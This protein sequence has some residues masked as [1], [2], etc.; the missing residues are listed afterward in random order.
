MIEKTLPGVDSVYLVYDDRDRVVATQD[1]EMR[2][3]NEWLFTKYDAMNRPVISGIMT[4]STSLTRSFIQSEIEDFYTSSSKRYEERTSTGNGYTDQTYP[5]TDSYIS[6]KTTHTIN[7]YDNYDHLSLTGFSGLSFDNTNNIDSYANDDG[8]SNGYFDR[9]INQLTGT[10]TILLDGSGSNWI[11]SSNYYDN[12]Y[13]IIQVKST[14]YPQGSTMLSTEFDFV[15]KVVENLEIQT[16]NSVENKIR[17]THSYDHAGRLK[18]KYMYYNNEIGILMAQNEYNELDE[19]VEKNLHSTDYSSFIQS[20]DYTYN[21]RGWLNGIND[22]ESLSGESDLFGLTLY[23]DDLD[24]GLGSNE[25]YNGNI[26]GMQWGRNGSSTSQAYA[27]TYDGLNRLT[28]TDFGT[29]TGSTWTTI[30]T[31]YET[32][33]SYDLNGNIDALTRKNSSGTTIDNVTYTYVGNQLGEIVDTESSSIGVIDDGISGTDYDYDDNGNMEWDRNKDIRV[34]YNHLNLPEKIYEESGTGDEILYI[35]DA[36]GIKWLKVFDDGSSENKTM[37]AGSFVYEDNDGD[38]V[39]DFGLDFILNSE[40]KIANISTTFEYHYHLKDHL[41]NTRVVFDGSGN[42]E[43]A[44]DYYPFG[45]LFNSSQGG[46]NEYLFN[47]KELQDEL[48]G[49]VNLDWYDYGAR[50]YDP[51]LGRWHSVD[52]MAEDY[53]SKSPYHFSGNN[54]V[55]FLDLNGMNYGDYYNTDGTWLG[56]D[57]IDDEK[58]YTADA[59]TKND[60]GIVTGA[61]NANELSISH[62]E[63]QTIS[64][65]VKHEVGTSDANENLWIAH[66][67]NNAANASETSLHSKLMS[68]YSS[69][70]SDIKLPLSTSANSAASNSARAGVLNVLTGGADPTGGS[71]LWDGTDFLAWGLNSPYGGKPHAKFRQYNNISISGDIYT[72]YLGSAQSK[73]P[74]GRV[75]YSGKYYNIPAA[76]FQDESNWTKSGF[77]YNTGYNR[78]YG[79]KATGAFGHSIFWKKVK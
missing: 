24:A 26:S 6:T 19:L 52:P 75:R 50:F 30:L 48:L 12:K 5:T 11:C 1:A 46:D 22:P 70:P 31:N 44:P 3:A 23:Y 7:Y 10:A 59:V 38:L 27:F 9:V 4:L 14:L 43:Q 66:T 78:S 45:M 47:G 42:T 40:G 74:K 51:A 64:A 36:T 25:T 20:V 35:Y 69:A 16:V 28:A 49:S 62:S 65:I 67:A 8:N 57:G 39:D 72:S 18:E 76:V 63:F 58:V 68:G 56:S 21:I 60:K 54:P 33:Y 34:D 41:G 77:N 71:T 55:R 37:Y 61:E 29:K 17:Y 15:G 79:I 53:A 73:Y 13:R 32:T 2:N